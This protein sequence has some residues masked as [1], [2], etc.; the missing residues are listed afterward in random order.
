MTPPPNSQVN[1]HATTNGKVPLPPFA[2]IRLFEQSDQEPDLRSWFTVLRRR[3]ILCGSVAAAVTVSMGVWTL[4]QTP[5]YE[6]RFQLLVEPVTADR[7][8]SSQ[9]AQPSQAELPVTGLDYDT[10][11]QVLRSPQLMQPIVKE[12]QSRYP[13]LSYGALVGGMSVTRLQ[14][15]KIL[16]IRY[17]DSDPE[18]IQFVLN[19]LS[20][21]YLRYSLQERQT[22]LRQGIQFVQDQLDTLQTRVDKLQE[23]LQNFRQRYNFI[24]PQTQ[25]EQIARRV[26]TIGQQ[27]L[28][29]Q[30]QLAEAQ[31]LYGNLQG[32]GA[33][34][35]LRDAAL[36]QRLLG[37]LRDVEVK[38]AV[39]SSRFQEANPAIQTLRDQQQ[40]LLP[41][42]RQE[43]RRTLG[44]KLA[45]VA[46]QIEV[47][48]VRSQAISQAETQLAE[49]LRQLP[50][51]SRRYTD[52][53]RDLNVATESLNRFLATRENLQVEAAQKDVP[54]QLLAAPEKPLFPTAP[55]I[56]RNL[57][58][59]AI[60]G[61]AMGIAAALL[62]ERLD[63]TFHSPEDLRD[64]TK[65]PLLGVVPFNQR[66]KESPVKTSALQA[67]TP[68]TPG[69]QARPYS[70]S[71]FL[72][73][74]R[75]LHANIRMLS[76]DAP[77][78]SLVVSSALPGD[79]KSTVAANLAQAAA[80]MG[81][82]VL[83]VDADLRRPQVSRLLHLPNMRG[84]STLITSD[85]KISHIIQRPPEEVTGL[86]PED[87]LFVLT[88]GPNPPDP[89][90]LLSSRKM[91]NWMAE[92]QGMFDLV[93]Y[94][95]PPLLG[96]ADSSLLAP[97]TDG[98][99]LIAGLAR[100]DRAAIAQ[101]I[102]TLKVAH[103]PLLG[104]VANGVRSQTAASYSYY[105][106]RYYTEGQTG[107]GAIEELEG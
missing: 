87:N 8:L 97:Y 32:P 40:N 98:V 100:T 104:V 2:P 11:I 30:K 39:E 89:T 68:A 47:L 103:I 16:E 12:L 53:Q 82:R 57:M 76:S 60:A 23:Q 99:V 64:Q 24:D 92:F 55:N 21:S 6:G 93:I 43:A 70:T 44:A 79:G 38:I 9:L 41:V 105:Y 83:L 42:L 91:Q 1:G 14:D 88:S 107:K 5:I 80:I 90:K 17:R 35:A 34:P 4:S 33:A 46:N 94:D 54:W 75:S 31:A 106:S 59:A 63:H 65:L 86:S 28:E 20:E 74:F 81:Q 62:A 25:A 50:V 45:E 66:L 58:L 78:R 49:Q 15:T 101:A 36:Y 72:E 27:K 85:A 71:N 13:S 84:L 77:I 3:A 73:A 56:Q 10:Q 26:E 69:Y 29:T 61:M 37:Q 95:T 48:Q 19:Q 102:D 96:L 67:A 51:L 18:K 52:L 22:N 7:K